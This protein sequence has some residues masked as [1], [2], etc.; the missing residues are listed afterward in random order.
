MLNPPPAVPPA[1]LPVALDEIG[2]A[3]AH[4]SKPLAQLGSPCCPIWVNANGDGPETDP[5]QAVREVCLDHP[6]VDWPCRY[7]RTGWTFEVATGKHPDGRPWQAWYVY[8]HGE[9]MFW[10][11]AL[12][13]AEQAIRDYERGLSAGR[14]R[15]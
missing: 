6:G 3:P 13:L 10:S 14:A 5:A 1:V 8:L 9:S 15:P 4:A 2:C 7:D 12:D 11:P